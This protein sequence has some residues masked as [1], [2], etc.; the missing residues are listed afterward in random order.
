MISSIQKGGFKMKRKK[1]DQIQS[2]QNNQA[3]KMTYEQVLRKIA[4]GSVSPLTA[5]LHSVTS[6][7]RPMPP[8][9]ANYL[10]DCYEKNWTPTQVIEDWI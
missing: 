6:G 3:Q 10:K 9:T 5:G 7:W 8:D 2:N 1:Q 4:E